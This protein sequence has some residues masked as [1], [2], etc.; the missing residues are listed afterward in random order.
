MKKLLTV[1]L[2]LLAFFAQAQERRTGIGLSYS[3]GYG[4][5]FHLKKLDGSGSNE[6][7][8]LNTLGVNYWHETLKNLHLEI[9]IQYLVYKYTATAPYY[10]QY[11]P[12]VSNHK[13][14]L[15]TIPIQL[16]YEIGRFIF[17]NGGLNLNLDA[18]EV[19]TFEDY[20]FGGIGA[21]VGIGLQH[22]FKN[23]VGIYVNPHLGLRN[24]ISFSNEGS[25]VSLA[26]ALLTFGLNYRIK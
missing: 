8:S 6:G 23:N 21:G 5:I 20:K 4:E 7:N 1:F 2:I 25:N 13:V 12:I 26:T 16:R 17:F 15:I 9:G 14:K 11:P 24:M 3:S 10:G 19:N 18:Q 22:Y